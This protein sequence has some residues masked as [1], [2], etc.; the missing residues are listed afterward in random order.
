VI[1]FVPN[2]PIYSDSQLRGACAKAT[3]DERERCA[4]LAEQEAN[5][6]IGEIGRIDIPLYRTADLIRQQP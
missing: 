1:R 2:V 3:A 4:R 6:R 5:D